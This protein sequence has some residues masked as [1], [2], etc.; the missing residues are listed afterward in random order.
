[1]HHLPE[2]TQKGRMEIK[3]NQIYVMNENGIWD[4]ARSLYTLE[5]KGEGKKL[6]QD[7][8]SSLS[9]FK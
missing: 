5:R 1:V 2:R 4:N 9:L 8:V 3:S 7:F 6:F